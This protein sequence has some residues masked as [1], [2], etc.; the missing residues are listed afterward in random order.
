MLSKQ[1]CYV[2][3]EGQEACWVHRRYW[4]ALRVIQAMK[5][6]GKQ[7]QKD[8]AASAPCCDLKQVET[9]VL[10]GYQMGQHE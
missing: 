10:A 4:D 5:S 6:M 8:G 3:I 2:E 7:C 9:R 1:T